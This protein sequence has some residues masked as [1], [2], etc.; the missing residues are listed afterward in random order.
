MDSLT[1]FSL[2]LWF[3]NIYGD[4]IHILDFVVTAWSQYY[5]IYINFVFNPSNN[6]FY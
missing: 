2:E 3:V 6:T 5:Q 4:I 1:V